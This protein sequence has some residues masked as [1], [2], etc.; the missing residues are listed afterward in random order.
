[1]QLLKWPY[2]LFDFDQFKIGNVYQKRLY[3]KEYCKILYTKNEIILDNQFY[4]KLK[5]FDYK[6]FLIV[7][8]VSIKS[9]FAPEVQMQPPEVMQVTKRFILPFLRSRQDSHRQTIVGCITSGWPAR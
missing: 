1:M 2:F 4:C 7:K 8:V 9:E 3:N 6:I 5:L